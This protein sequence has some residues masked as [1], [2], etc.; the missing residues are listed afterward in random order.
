MQLYFLTIQGLAY[1][2]GSVSA[3]LH[4]K[5]VREVKH[6]FRTWR[7]AVRVFALALI[8]AAIPLPSLAEETKKPTPAPGLRVSIARATASSGVTLSQATPSTAPDRSQLD[9][10]SFFKSPAG[11]L[12]LAVV[13]VGTGYAVYSTGHD[14]IHS[15][16]RKNQ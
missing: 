11:M 4:N 15:V 2:Y 9:S 7:L 6:Q 10:K 14:R 12:V 8:V 5:E 3:P 13:A 16:V 1:P